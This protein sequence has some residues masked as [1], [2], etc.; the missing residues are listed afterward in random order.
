[1]ELAEILTRMKEGDDNAPHLLF[2]QEGRS[3]FA[4]LFAHCGDR[5]RAKAQTQE[6]FG[7][8]RRLC[9]TNPQRV[10]DAEALR[11]ALDE[12]VAQRCAEVEPEPT[13]PVGPPPEPAEA[14]NQPPPEPAAVQ[15]QPPPEPAAV[16]ARAAQSEIGALADKYAVQREP[17]VVLEQPDDAAPKPAEAAAPS[18]ASEQMFREPARVRIAANKRQTGGAARSVRYWLCFALLVLCILVLLW[19]VVGMVMGFGW[20]PRLDLGYTWFNENVCSMF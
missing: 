13:L 10:P 3:V 5:E 15:M 4:R 14:Y 17:V 18:A 19:A 7:D 9:L 11:C 16:A 1:M 20:L 8:L 6:V 2:L 12:L